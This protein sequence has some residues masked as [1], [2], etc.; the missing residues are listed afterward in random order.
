MDMS[1]EDWNDEFLLYSYSSYLGNQK[2]DGAHS[3]EL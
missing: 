2:H 3:V 1:R